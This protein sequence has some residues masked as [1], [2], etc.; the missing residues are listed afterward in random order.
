[1]MKHIQTSRAA[2]KKAG[3]E[4]LIAKISTTSV[5]SSLKDLV[6]RGLT[7][8][9]VGGMV[10]STGMA[11]LHAREAVLTSK[12]A[13]VLRNDIL[14]KDKNSLV[15]LLQDF[16]KAYAG[17]GSAALNVA[18]NVIIENASINMNIDHIANDYDARRA[19]EQAL[20]EMMRIARKNGTANSISRR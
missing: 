6:A 8:Y 19:G 7:A 14:G 17:I 20:T 15:N 13:D 10:D 5:K 11:L 9:D 18:P 2:G 16:R 12:Q 4:A 3:D 1:M